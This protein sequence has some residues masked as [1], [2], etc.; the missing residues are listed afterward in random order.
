MID[1]GAIIN[2]IK[3]YKVK[4]RWMVE[5][6]RETT[7]Y[8]ADENQASAIALQMFHDVTRYSERT[9]PEVIEIKKLETSIL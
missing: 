3:R 7:L 9:R 1:N 2:N 5:E 6:F 4:I 8:A